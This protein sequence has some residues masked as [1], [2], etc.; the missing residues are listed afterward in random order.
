MDNQKEQNNQHQKNS[1][2]RPGL[3]QKDQHPL[4]RNNKIFKKF[5]LKCLSLNADNLK[6]K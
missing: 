6:I 1:P 2:R 3:T 5:G 4:Q